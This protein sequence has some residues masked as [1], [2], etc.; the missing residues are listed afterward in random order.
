MSTCD[1]LTVALSVGA[2]FIAALALVMCY[3]MALSI[4]EFKKDIRTI[5]TSEDSDEVHRRVRDLMRG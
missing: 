1:F 2:F 3:L 4:G 5:I